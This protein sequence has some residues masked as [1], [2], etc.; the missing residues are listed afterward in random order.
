MEASMKMPEPVAWMDDA[1]SEG[2][3]GNVAMTPNK[4]YW[5]KLSGVDRRNAERLKHPLYDK[6]ALIDLLEALADEIKV[7]SDY[8]GSNRRMH[9]QSIL[10]KI[11]KLKETL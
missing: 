10:P 1:A 7:E 8:S 11:Q 6:Q 4:R 3:I 2:K 5:E 9:L